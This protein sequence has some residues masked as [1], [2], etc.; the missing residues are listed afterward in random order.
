MDPRQNLLALLRQGDT[1]LFRSLR[2]GGGAVVMEAIAAGKPIFCMD[3]AGPGVHVT[4]DCGIKI[5][6]LICR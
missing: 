3:L 2:D 4:E 6:S 5:P 1:F